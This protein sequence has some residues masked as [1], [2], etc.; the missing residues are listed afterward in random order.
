MSDTASWKE[1]LGASYRLAFQTAEV[2]QEEALLILK[3]EVRAT[4]FDDRSYASPGVSDD[5]AN[6]CGLAVLRQFD[7]LPVP[8]IRQV[9]RR[10]EFW[11][12]AVTTLD[13]GD[14]T[15]FARAVEGWTRAVGES[16]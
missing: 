10:A 1:T 2:M 5:V 7:G 11:L 4:L 13:C 9:L 8:V 15:E 14:A 3:A 6:M 16:R 12:G